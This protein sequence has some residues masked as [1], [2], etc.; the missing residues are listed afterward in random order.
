MVD[1]KV[2]KIEKVEAAASKLCVESFD[3]IDPG[4]L[5]RLTPELF[6]QTVQS[7]QL[8]CPSLP[9]SLRVATFCE[10]QAAAVNRDFL[11]AVAPASIMPVV[12]ESVALFLLQQALVHDPGAVDDSSLRKRC[13]RALAPKWKA[14]LQ[15]Q[16]GDTPA[17]KRQKFSIDYDMPLEAKL[18]LAITVLFI[19]EQ[20]T[21][22]EKKR[23]D[24][25]RSRACRL[26]ILL[27]ILL[28]DEGLAELGSEELKAFVSHGH[29]CPQP[30]KC[31]V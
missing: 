31:N 29:R 3:K 26:A 19:C 17:A 11:E 12:D 21:E 7:P 22:E 27:N 1:A 10:V 28:R 8:K 5:A 9:L 14:L 4:T 15:S 16:E 23:A 2:Y 30:N 20:A 13:M 18:E 24:D 25:W 6:M